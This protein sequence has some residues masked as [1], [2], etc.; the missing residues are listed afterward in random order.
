MS[1]Q[2]SFNFDDN[3]IEDCKYEKGNSLYK[4]CVENNKTDLLKE[5]D[6]SKNGN[7]TPKIVTPRSKDKVWWIVHYND[8][9]TSKH[10]DFSWE[11]AI[12][13]R[14]A[15]AGCPFLSNPVKAVFPGFN[16]LATTNSEL[17]SDWNYE[18]NNELGISITEVS[19][20]S[21][22]IVF[23]NCGIHGSYEARI[24]DRVHGNGCPYCAGKKIKIG[25]ND[26][27]TTNPKMAMEWD[28]EKNGM[29]PENVTRGCIKKYWWKCEK[30]HSWFVSPNN[31]TNQD[32]D[33]PYCTNRKVWIGFNDLGT[34]YPELAKEWNY[35]KNGDL[36]P[37]TVVAKSDKKVWWYC[38]F[39]HEYE[40]RIS[41]RVLDGIGCSICN[42]ERR[43][44]FPEKAIYYYVKKEFS[45]AEE[46]LRFNWLGKGELDMFIP[47]LNVGIEY[48]GYNWHKDINKDLKKDTACF[49]NNVDLIRVRV[50]ECPKYDSDS[51]KIYY[52]KNSQLV[53]LDDAI[54]YLFNY[55]NQKYNVN[56]E[57]N[58]NID[59]DY[60]EIMDNYITREKQNSLAIMR[61]DIAKEWNYEKNGRIKPEFVSVYSNRKVW[62]TCSICGNDYQTIINNR[63][64]SK[65]SGCQVCS[66]KKI[67]KGVNDFGTQFP[68]LL[69]EWDYVKNTISPYEI[70]PGN[71]KKIWWKCSK[72]GHSWEAALCSRT[73]KQKCGCPVCGRQVAGT[74]NNFAVLYP[75]LLEEWCYDK[76]ERDPYTLL[77]QSN[78]K[79]WWK[80]K[81][82]EYEWQR[83]LYHRTQRH[84]GCPLCAHQVLVKGI[85]DL[86]TQFPEVAKEWNYE[87]NVLKPYEVSGGT[88]KKYWWKCSICGYEWEC[89]VAS[90]TKRG[91]NC[92]KCRK[93]HLND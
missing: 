78:L 36:T 80:C 66:H 74:E 25:F 68:H 7:K 8:P 54:I 17:A 67:K 58:I 12:L 22:K 64:G 60:I 61:P 72:C 13:H 23:W 62:F 89:V 49:N 34:V 48:D 19:R 30:G 51:Y 10:F 91:S 93:R 24:A 14:T 15:G 32:S 55:L 63:T 56:I 79:F 44:S 4:W 42:K 5:W 84:G 73:G 86:E 69:E 9:V 11:T 75:E 45:D 81:K 2:L 76:N 28:T 90:R 70:S 83:D 71:H 43:T 3:S 33:C 85:N 29:G 41:S 26:L 21:T 53:T 16:D 57:L 87:K 50:D 59:R 77:P 6:Y 47:S 82:C 92:P 1:R 39:G 40:C 27:V 52:G 65:K 46:N 38:K 31:R 20:G 35:E 88:N 37:Q 18:K